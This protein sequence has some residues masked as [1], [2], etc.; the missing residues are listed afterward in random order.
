MRKKPDKTTQDIWSLQL[1]LRS[2]ERQLEEMRSGKAYER[3]EESRKKLIREYEAKVKALVKE[4]KISTNSCPAI[5]R[6]KV[7]N[8]LKV[9]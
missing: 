6:K 8:G 9:A 5:T 3:L 1:K 7:V 4:Q 2:L